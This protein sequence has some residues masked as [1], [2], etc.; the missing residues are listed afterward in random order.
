MSSSDS[1]HDSETEEEIPTSCQYN[2]ETTNVYVKNFD[3][4]MNE[5]QLCELF[6]KYGTITSCMVSK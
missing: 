4:D 1:E 3:N 5:R 2:E 6:T